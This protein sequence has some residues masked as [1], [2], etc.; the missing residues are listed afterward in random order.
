MLSCNT[1][2]QSLAKP[3]IFEQIKD[4]EYALIEY[5]EYQH[6]LKLHRSMLKMLTSIE[7]PPSKITTNR[8]EDFVKKF[9]RQIT[10]E[11]PIINDLDAAIFDAQ[12]ALRICQHTL[13]ILKDH[14]IEQKGIHNLNELYEALEKRELDMSQWLDAV[15]KGDAEWFESHG[16]QFKVE[17]AVL[18][19]VFSKP[20]QPRLEEIARK[21]P[22][23][24]LNQWWQPICPVCAR[25]PALAWFKEGKRYLTCSFCGSQYLANRFLCV[26]C[27]NTDPY[28]LGFYTFKNFSEFQIDFCEKCKHYI[29][30]IYDNK[31]KKR[32][33]RGLE[34]YLTQRLDELVIEAGLRR[35]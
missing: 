26:N 15:L 13:S 12:I 19:F 31:L 7:E 30:V 2:E 27:G 16:K 34:D 18:I 32:I 21:I 24:A 25:R 20:I 14:R 33:P 8:W 22:A 9:S 11:K 28:S 29:K 17:P 5:P 10:L 6:S 1:G 4:V 35:I 23:S 3:N